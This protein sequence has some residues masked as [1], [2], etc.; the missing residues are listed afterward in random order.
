MSFDD[1][2]NPMVPELLV[3]N[4]NS[5]LKFYTNLLGFNIQFQRT[6]PDFAYLD[7]NY[8]QL[9]LEQM[10]DDI[11]NVGQM[12]IPFGRG[13]NLQIE[14]TDVQTIYKNLKLANISI[15]REIKETWYKTGS[16]ESGQ[17]EF[18]IQD[19]D[20]YLLRFSQHLGKRN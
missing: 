15:F 12:E 14:V 16:Y 5:S 18:L 11:W 10:T 6:N 19:P 20:G 9:M 4:F 8:A 3:T 7:L 17:K 1:K 13:I 2:W